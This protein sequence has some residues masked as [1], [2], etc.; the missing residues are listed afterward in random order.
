MYGIGS[1]L[2]NVYI[3]RFCRTLKHEY[4][5]LNPSNGG[6]DL[7]KGAK[8]YVSLYNSERYHSGAGEC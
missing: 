8:A 5:Y 2:D 4:V 7:Y 1:A 6:V 3:K